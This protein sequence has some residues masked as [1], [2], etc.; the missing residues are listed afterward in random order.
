M[1][2]VAWPFL[3]HNNKRSGKMNR[4]HQIRTPWSWICTVHRS[5]LSCWSWINSRMGQ[6][7]PGT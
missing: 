5:L 4:I 2:Y 1:Q 6:H 3:N 7:S